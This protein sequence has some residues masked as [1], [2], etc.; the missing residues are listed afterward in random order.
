MGISAGVIITGEGIFEVDVD[1]EE[2]E[3]EEEEEVEEEDDDVVAAAPGFPIMAA[4]ATAGPVVLIEATE[5]PLGKEKKSFELVLSQQTL[6]A[7]RL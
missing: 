1:E 3:E 5:V 6:D 2:E 7:F 4:D